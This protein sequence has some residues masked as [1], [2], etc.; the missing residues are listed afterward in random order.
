MK[1]WKWKL[2]R[3]PVTRRTMQTIPLREMKLDYKLLINTCVPLVLKGAEIKAL[4]SGFPKH[5]T[6]YCC[7]PRT[8][9]QL[10]FDPKG[11]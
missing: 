10:K 8:V 4:L 7:W 3:L 2:F 1:S 6:L 9:Q 5:I 11:K